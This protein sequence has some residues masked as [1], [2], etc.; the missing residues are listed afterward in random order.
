ML[1]A[2]MR[3]LLHTHP[4][5]RDPGATLTAA[6]DM[7]HRLIPS[8]L[9]MTGLYLVLG[10]A[11][12]VSWACAGHHPPLW[13]D[14]SGRLAPI[15]LDVIG[16]VLGFSAHEEYRTVSWDLA[17]GDRLL[18]FTDG[19]WEAR[20]RAG[21]PFGRQRLCEHLTGTVGLPL[22]EAVQGLVTRVAAHLEGA[23]F[24]DD[25]TVVGVERSD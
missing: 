25:F 15:D 11:G 1:M 5:H 6:S 14:R 3:T 8:D 13:A 18:L 7:F 17:P 22:A 12:R 10:A 2:I 4:V 21:E 20:S 19:I 16:A 9:F 23:D 24:E